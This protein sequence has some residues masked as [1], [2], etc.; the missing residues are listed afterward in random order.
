MVITFSRCITQVYI[1]LSLGQAECFLLTVMAWDRYVAICNPFHYHQVMNSRVCVRLAVSTWAGGFLIALSSVVV[2]PVIHFCGH[3]IIDHIACE[4]TALLPLICMDGQYSD[5]A[6]PFFALFVLVIPLSL[7]IF[8][9]LRILSTILRMPTADRRQRTFTT[10]GSHL[11]AVTLFYGTS[12]GIH[13][14]PKSSVSPETHKSL[15][16]FYGL[17]V[18]ALHPLIY[19]LRN[20]EVKMYSSPLRFRD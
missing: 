13:L 10:C 12:M 19:T 8:T 20:Q 17:M 9:Y 2:L 14:T 3:N 7:I 16:V 15:S 18:P 5:I 1:G 6:T 11:V 4:A